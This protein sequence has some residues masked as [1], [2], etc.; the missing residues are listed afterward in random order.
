MTKA[1]RPKKRV[2]N[3]VQTRSKL[4]QATI[5]LVTEKGADALSL[6][7]AAIRANVSRG[8]AYLHFH[9]RDHLLDEAQ[10]WI[11]NRLR[12]GMKRL[13]GESMHDR[14]LY[15][16][17]VVLENPA[18]SKLMITSALAG[19]ELDRNGGLYKLVTKMLA[20][21]KDRGKVRRDFDSEVLTYIMFGS[22]AATLMLAEQNKG[23]DMDELAERFTKEWNRV[24][25]DGIFVKRNPAKARPPSA[26]AKRRAT[27][28]VAASRV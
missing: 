10:H 14:T 27:R 8:V 20:E 9:D 4:L 12:D 2:R 18:A 22:I 3:P 25:N 21:L 6:K 23:G 17:K 13:D 24:L 1:S 15:T 26:P 5:D 16:T 7:E 28:K 11:A 19:K